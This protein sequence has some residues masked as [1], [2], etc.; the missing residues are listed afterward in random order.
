[1]KICI[2]TAQLGMKYG[3]AN[4]SSKMKFDDFSKILNLS[5]KNNIRFIDTAI[6][7]GNSE[8]LIGKAIIK[9]KYRKVIYVITK[10]D[11]L[12][13]IPKKKNF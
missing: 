12:R 1:M 5:L 6:N 8:E 4:K 3:I 9:N 13:F 7:Y 2:G 10:I 11:K